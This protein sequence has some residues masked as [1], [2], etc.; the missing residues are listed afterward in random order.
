M[1]W[2]SDTQKLKNCL[3]IMHKKFLH[4]GDKMNKPL[5]TK[6]E[7]YNFI[8]NSDQKYFAV[9][10]NHYVTHV[11]RCSCPFSYFLEY[12][13]EDEY[14]E[15]CTGFVDM[16]G[17]FLGW[18]DKEVVSAIKKYDNEDYPSKITKR[19]ALIRLKKALDLK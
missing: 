11:F 9:G 2:K 15:Y 4:R 7:F 14:L 10:E 5:L 6:R 8:K 18:T 13:A 1:K 19:R 16:C 12:I 3:L 17:M